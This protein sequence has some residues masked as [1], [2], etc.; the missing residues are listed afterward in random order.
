MNNLWDL[1]VWLTA[2][3]TG[4]TALLA[5]RSMGIY[6]NALRPFFPDFVEGR[7][8][9]K[10]LGAMVFGL[11]AGSIVGSGIPLALATGILNGPLLFFAAGVIGSLVEPVWLAV[12]L[13]AAWGILVNFGLHLVLSAASALP[14]NFLPALANI[15][16]PLLP[17]FSLF[18]AIAV[19]RQYGRRAGAV[20][21][22]LALFARQAVIVYV[23]KFSPEAAT[24]LVSIA[25]LFWL[26]FTRKADPA[27]VQADSTAPDSNLLLRRAQRLRQNLPYLVLT[28]AVIAS[29]CYL[30]V[31]GKSSVSVFALSEGRI[32]DAALADAIDDLGFLP[33]RITTIMVTG[34]YSI[35]GLFGPSI[36]YLSPN[37]GVAALAGGVA[38]L[39]EAM[40]ALELTRLVSRYPAMAQISQHMTG[41]MTMAMEV[42]L[43]YGSLLAGNAMAGS[44]GVFLVI[45]LYLFNEAAGSP[46]R[47]MAAGPVAAIAAGLIVNVLA[48]AR[49]LP[50]V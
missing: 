7:I 6:F 40:G 42:G 14:V 32:A 22:L 8:S 1:R 43:L 23:P 48:L 31:F 26:T 47:R 16:A 41:A 13:G 21:L 35:M 39:V 33:V 9:R 46:V 38:V 44:L 17:A 10:E 28:G 25:G 12:V 49:L 37:I 45:A 11:S 5:N 24:I 15:G 19:V 36:A 4:L 18:P 34:V 29:L 3:A 50:P 27:A 2:A 30:R 20:T